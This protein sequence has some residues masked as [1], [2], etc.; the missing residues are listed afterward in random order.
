MP[1]PMHRACRALIIMLCATLFLAAPAAAQSGQAS[2]EQLLQEA[3]LAQEAGKTFDPE[4]GNAFSLYLQVV[5]HP[6][7][8]AEPKTRRLTD[9]MAGTSP[10]QQA[11]YSLNELF[12]A[13]LERV[14]DALAKG[15]L[16]DA[17][18]IIGMLEKT[19]ANSPSVQ[20]Y[21]RNHSNALAAAREGLRSSSPEGLPVLVTSFNPNY[22]ARARRQG[23]S[24]WV[25]IAFTIQ[26][27]G[28]VDDLKVMAAEPTGMFER[29]S[30]RA[31]EKWK[32][33]PSGRTHRAQQRFDFIAD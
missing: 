7:A 23:I 6:D 33:E 25:V 16:V 9:A 1:Y 10:V 14:E 12:Q 29:D 22:S 8:S 24:G 21:R 5:E 15:E 20:R 30:V 32:F 31:L 2:I 11:Q 13:G 28:S 19:Q 18:R 3:R 4:E 26:A 17:G 27:D